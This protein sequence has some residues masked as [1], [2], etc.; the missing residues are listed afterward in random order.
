[1]SLL[2]VV[3]VLEHLLLPLLEAEGLACLACTSTKLKQVV[4][5]CSVDIWEAA[6]R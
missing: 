2:G 5:D 1:M 4:Y 3:G 6:A